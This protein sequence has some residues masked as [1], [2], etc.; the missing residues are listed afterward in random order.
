[1]KNPNEHTNY[2][3]PMNTPLNPVFGMSNSLDTTNPFLSESVY[4]GN[5]VDEH[6]TLEQ[7]NAYLAEK[8]L[9]QIN[10]NS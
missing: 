7:A 6:T 1:M 5:S 10:E 8:E 9:G 2:D 3:I 4:A